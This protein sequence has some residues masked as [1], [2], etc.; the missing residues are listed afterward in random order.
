M[1]TFYNLKAITA[2][3]TASQ[4]VDII[5]SK[6]Q[7]KTP[8]VIHPSYQITRIRH[9]Y[10]RKVKFAQDE[11]EE[12]LDLILKEFPKLDVGHGRRSTRTLKNKRLI[13]LLPTVRSLAKPHY[14]S[15]LLVCSVTGNPPILRRSPQ[16]PLRPRPLQTRPRTNQHGQTPRPKRRQR[17]CPSPQIRRLALPLQTTQARSSRPHVHHHEAT[18]GFFSVLGTSEAAHGQVARH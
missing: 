8:T 12:R 18:K 17:L 10:M 16:R 6:L 14:R 15:L 4:F 3:P 9:F 2:V 7:R 1:A 5:L 11:F 13:F